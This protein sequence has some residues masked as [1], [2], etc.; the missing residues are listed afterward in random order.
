M[1]QVLSMAGKKDFIS[2][3]IMIDKKEIIV[4]SMKSS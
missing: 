3:S 1:N 4:D 2:N